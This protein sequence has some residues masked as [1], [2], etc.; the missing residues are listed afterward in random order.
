[1]LVLF[2]LDEPVSTDTCAT[3]PA[4]SDVKQQHNLKMGWMW[5]DQRCLSSLSFTHAFPCAWFRAWPLYV[6]A[7]GK[8]NPNST[9]VGIATTRRCSR[10]FGPLGDANVAE[11]VLHHRRH[12]L[13]HRH[14]HVHQYRHTFIAFFLAVLIMCC[15]RVCVVRF[16]GAVDSACAPF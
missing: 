14:C 8:C 5:D 15:T 16:H 4:G 11:H 1:M 6:R 2:W 10:S 7:L 9:C 13:Q 3:E 12:V